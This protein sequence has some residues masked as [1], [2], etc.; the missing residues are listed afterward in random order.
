MQALAALGYGASEALKAVNAVEGA[1][2]L[3]VEE[4]LKAAL[5]RMARF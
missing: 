3:T 5:K 1:G 4:L 2:E